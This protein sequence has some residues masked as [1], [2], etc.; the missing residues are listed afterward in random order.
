MRKILFSMM[1][2]FFVLN[3]TAIA[4]YAETNSLSGDGQLQDRPGL[5]TSDQ[6]RPSEGVQAQ[7]QDA[8]RKKGNNL[9][10]SLL[11]IALVLAALSVFP[12]LMVSKVMRQKETKKTE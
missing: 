6:N 12:I 11:L 4:L 8:G 3:S 7:T 10:V 2:I 1:I 5:N 9:V